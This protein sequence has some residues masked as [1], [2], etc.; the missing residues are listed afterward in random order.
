MRGYVSHLAD[1][2]TSFRSRSGRAPASPSGAVIVKSSTLRSCSVRHKASRRRKGRSCLSR[3]MASRVEIDH[4]EQ[5]RVYLCV[6]ERD[7]ER[8]RERERSGTPSQVHEIGETTSVVSIQRGVLDGK[9]ASGSGTL[10]RMLEWEL[11]SFAPDLQDLGVFVG[12]SLDRVSSL[13]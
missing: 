5:V 12:V 7:R 3:L 6:R 11:D 2:K 10:T 1:K 8:E 4:V 9:R 13:G